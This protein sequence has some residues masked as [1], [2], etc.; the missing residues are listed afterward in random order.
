MNENNNQ[1]KELVD[2]F[3][4]TNREAILEVAKEGSLGQGISVL[5]QNLNTHTSD[6]PDAIHIFPDV[7]TD[8]IMRT[9]LRRHKVIAYVYAHIAIVKQWTITQKDLEGKTKEQVNQMIDE[10]PEKQ[11][12]LIRYV[13]RNSE[14]IEVFN[15]RD[16]GGVLVLD[17]D[18][19][20]GLHKS[21]LPGQN[22]LYE[23][24]L[25]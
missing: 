22:W 8:K 14:K 16:V 3:F 9:M 10:L 12:L 19:E 1:E 6:I 11:M 18:E 2:A 24:S 15:V 13:H 17:K 4:Q 7:V 20:L 5:D 21:K 23:P 25:N